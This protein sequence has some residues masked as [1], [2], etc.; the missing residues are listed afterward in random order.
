MPYF[1]LLSHNNDTCSDVIILRIRIFQSFSSE[2]L[3]FIICGDP[4]NFQTE[5]F[6]LSENTVRK[7]ENLKVT[8]QAFLRNFVNFNHFLPYPNYIEIILG[9]S[10]S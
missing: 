2:L 4:A 10:N 9:S 1:T 6:F 7:A 5:I 8:F 3:L